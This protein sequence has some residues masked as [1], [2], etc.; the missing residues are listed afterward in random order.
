MET[1]KGLIYSRVFRDPWF[2]PAFP[3]VSTGPGFG[4]LIEK[5]LYLKKIQ[6]IS[7]FHKFNM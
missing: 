6:S 2:F 4:Y 7:I 5:A 3:R 1:H